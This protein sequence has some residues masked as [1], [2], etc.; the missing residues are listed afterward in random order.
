MLIDD[1]ARRDFNRLITY[2]RSAD[3]FQDVPFSLPHT[4]AALDQAFPGS[5]FILTVR[6]DGAEW[7]DSLTRFHSKLI[8]KNRIPTV[9][10]L[11]AFNYNG[12]GWLWAAHQLA[13][14]VQPADLYAPGHY[15][16]QYDAHNEQVADY[17]RHRPDD[18][19]VLN[20]GRPDA[21]ES[22][23]RFLKMPY[24]GERMPHLNHSRQAA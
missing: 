2:C 10:D 24:H 21:M 12:Q 22:L 1:W 3:A 17:F 14:R 16:P 8:G 5:K 11:Q 20:V 4:Y 15:I 13:Y 6:N 18:L 19:L 9:D 23:C 7:F